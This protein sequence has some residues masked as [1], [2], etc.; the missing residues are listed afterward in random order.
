[1]KELLN[2]P[3]IPGAVFVC[4]D[5]MA[6]GALSAAFEMGVSV[7]ETISVIGFDDIRISRYLNPPLTTIHFPAAEMGTLAVEVLM[8]LLDKG[9]TKLD[10]ENIVLDPQ[11]IIRGSTAPPGGK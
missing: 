6:M 2:L 11:L 1:M 7:P 3:E 5:Y 8:Q 10:L 4:N 9:E